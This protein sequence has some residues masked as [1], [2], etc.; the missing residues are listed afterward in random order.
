MFSMTGCSL[1]QSSQS[2]PLASK[3]TT[4]ESEK[5]A[6]GN[7]D[8]ALPTEVAPP[9]V[10]PS[11]EAPSEEPAS[12]EIAYTT[13]K[14]AETSPTQTVDIYLPDEQ[15]ESPYPV[16]VA[17]HGGSF[18]EGNS[19]SLD[20]APIAEATKH[21]YAVVSVNY[22]LADEAV[23]P[24]AVNDVKAAIRFVKAQAETYHFNSEKIAVWG[25]SAGANLALMAAVSGSETSAFE[26][27]V[28]ENLDFNSDV[29]AVVAWFAPTDF[30]SFGFR[31]SAITARYLG[32]DKFNDEAQ[33]KMASPTTYISD[34]DPA[35][36]PHFLIQH[37]TAD[38]LVP[39]DQATE[40]NNLIVN[41]LGEEMV[42]F[43]PIENVGHG[44]PEFYTEENMNKVYD[45]L[46]SILK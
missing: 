1:S 8:S 36:A 31:A 10:E 2:P 27:D 16:I 14:Y 30:V 34:L 46:D 39:F 35:T 15:A 11:K 7:E 26:N 25:D 37:G 19:Q 22:R 17:V 23:F 44:A 29:Q 3:T 20:I 12:E 9:S 41:A 28:K 5:P 4:P 42:S 38:T 13:V 21:G 43:I 18:I 6:L 40:L 32:Q 33:M 24:A 45:F